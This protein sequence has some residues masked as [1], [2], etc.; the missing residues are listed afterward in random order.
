[1]PKQKST[2]LIILGMHRSGTSCLA[3]SLQQA[4]VYLGEVSKYNEYN[5]KGNKENERTMKLNE[6]I[7]KFNNSSWHTPPSKLVWTKAH[8]SEGNALIRSFE[9]KSNSQY[10]GFKDP[11]V[12]LTLPFWEKLL[13]QAKYVGTYR[14]PISVSQSLNNRAE[15]SIETKLGLNLWL[16]YNHMLIDFFNKKPFPLISFDLSAEDYKDKLKQICSILNLSDVEH[17]DFFDG[18]LRNQK[19][20]KLMTGNNDIDLMYNKLLYLSATQQPI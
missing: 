14:N 20:N 17:I 18:N 11:R 9:K 8:E 10:W 6:T 5:K 13:P 12:L 7:L 15:Y 1:M 2:P 3:G 16:H 4:G 19:N